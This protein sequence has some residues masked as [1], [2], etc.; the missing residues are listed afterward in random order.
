MT[1]RRP[2]RRKHSE[3]SA[4]RSIRLGDQTVAFELVRADRK[5]VGI[6]VRPDGSVVVRAPRRTREADVLRR[7][8]GHADWILRTRCRLAEAERRR[9]LRYEDGE[10]HL[11]L[12]RPYLLT[13]E[14]AGDGGAFASGDVGSH[15]VG[16]A[17]GGDAAAD[18]VRLLGDT[19]TVTLDGEASAE[20]IKEVL[21]AWYE[22]EARR[23]LPKRLAV[24]WTA[25]GPALHTTHRASGSKRSAA[26]IGGTPA[27]P[28]LRVKRMRSR[29]G[30]MSP[31]GAMS[32]RLDLVRAP[33]ECIDYVIV[34]ELCHLVHPHH[35]PAFWA[36]VEQLMPDWKRRRRRLHELLP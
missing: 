3:P 25:V 26:G 31:K 23:V 10:A 30:S 29:W 13:I 6:R 17:G 5:T 8:T 32:L 36:L 7:V 20:R 27:V 33:V 28:A 35:Q 15:N 9:R 18:P 4:S 2:S 11:Y 16:D 19:M 21:D 1:F 22:E 34:H 24:C 12:G 14:R